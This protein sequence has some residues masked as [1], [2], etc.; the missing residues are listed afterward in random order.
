M[1]P[2]ET[3]TFSKVTN[4]F[5]YDEF[6]P[7]E[8]DKSSFKGRVYSKALEQGDS[9]TESFLD[10]FMNTHVQKLFKHN[11][12]I[13]VSPVEYLKSSKYSMAR[14]AFDI[15]IAG[16]LTGIVDTITALAAT[17]GFGIA[18][19]VSGIKGAVNFALS[20]GKDTHVFTDAKSTLSLAG[21]LLT[22]TVRSALRAVPILG[23]GLSAAANLAGSAVYVKVD[24][25][26]KNKAL[27]KE[28][29][30]LK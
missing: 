28:T 16:P 2:T 8:T 10:G 15:T 13:S 1:K 9:I 3:S 18:G 17:I 25:F 14:K 26:I 11:A 20:K 6:V 30:E 12:K 4:K 5:S 7:K 19:I 24:E 29:E 22:H 23:V 21:I 27:A